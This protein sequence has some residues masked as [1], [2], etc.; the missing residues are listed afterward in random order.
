MKKFLPVVITSSLVIP[1]TLYAVGL[2]GIKVYS[3]LNQ[4]LSAEIQLSDLGQVQLSDVRASLAS[5]KQ[6]QEIGLVPADALAELKFD[7]TYN[8]RGLPV[9]RISSQKPVTDPSLQFAID[10]KWPDGSYVRAYTLLL[11][12]VNYHISVGPK[13]YPSRKT[14]SQTE[15]PQ[16]RVSALGKQTIYG[17][18][19]HNEELWHI[20]RQFKQTASQRQAMVAIVRANPESFIHGNMNG[21]KTGV[22]LVIPSV[23]EMKKISNAKAIVLQHQ[24]AWASGEIIYYSKRPEQTQQAK[25][26]SP[27]PAHHHYQVNASD[28]PTAEEPTPFMQNNALAQPKTSP[29]EPALSTAKPEEIDSKTLA[30]LE[31]QAQSNAVQPQVASAEAEK[32]E[33][34][35]EVEDLAKENAKLKTSLKQKEHDFQ[36]LRE[37]M[38][39]FAQHLQDKVAVDAASGR[40]PQ[41]SQAA[42]LTQDDSGIAWTFLLSI[43]LLAG[44]AFAYFRFTEQGRE[45]LAAGL[46]WRRWQDSAKDFDLE[47]SFSKVKQAF[48]KVKL[49]DWGQVKQSQT[50]E[51]AADTESSVELDRQNAKQEPVTTPMEIVETPMPIDSDPAPQHDEVAQID[52][53]FP[54]KATAKQEADSMQAL[55]DAIVEDIAKPAETAQSSLVEEKDAPVQTQQDTIVED[56]IEPEATAET[57]DAMQSLEEAIVESKQA[58]ATK[59]TVSEA[60]QQSDSEVDNL[61]EFESGLA[62]GLSVGRKGDR[63][64]APESDAGEAALNLSD[65]GEDAIDAK[66]ALAKTY[67]DNQDHA[68]ALL[69]L[70][71]VRMEGNAEQKQEAEKLLQSLS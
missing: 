67:M 25:A 5:P 54:A 20:A 34:K 49:P 3:A 38:M 32:Q 42:A 23:A 45:F 65:L 62:D 12:P 15:P 9:I 30:L 6:F 41:A 29:L 56:L 70:E 10:L 68:S 48:S 51:V 36:V 7:V 18:V 19:H 31:Q 40:R 24:K 35:H 13:T 2:S 63:Q 50:D 47:S 43:F 14:L 61:I 58:P 16:P 69:L 71:E 60:P 44:G 27:E 52:R 59:E 28:I 53:L 4:P 22:E 11:D 21:L 39:V 1:S 66:L 17:P 57:F 37:E 8:K 26:A 55:Q 33:L 64:D 46:P